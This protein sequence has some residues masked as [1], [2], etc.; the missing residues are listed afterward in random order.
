MGKKQHTHTGR[1]TSAIWG[2]KRK[3][4]QQEHLSW[5]YGGWGRVHQ[6]ETGRMESETPR[7]IER[8]KCIIYS[9]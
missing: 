9:E 1:V 7:A 2:I 4:V 8:H 5:D 6:A 3:S